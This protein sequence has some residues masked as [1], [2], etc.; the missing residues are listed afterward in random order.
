MLSTRAWR[1]AVMMFSLTP[2]VPH[3]RAP[4]LLWIRTRVLAALGPVRI[5]RSDSPQEAARVLGE[6]I[7]YARQGEIAAR[8]ARRKS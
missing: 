6:A 5:S 8:R 3:S 4:S 1:D 2:T 7:D